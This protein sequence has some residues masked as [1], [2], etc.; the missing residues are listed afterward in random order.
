MKNRELLDKLDNIE[1]A[2]KLAE[3]LELIM[4]TRENVRSLNGKEAT[5]QKIFEL[6]ANDIYKYLEQEV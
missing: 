3:Q 2:K 6:C 1:Y 5:R 4:A